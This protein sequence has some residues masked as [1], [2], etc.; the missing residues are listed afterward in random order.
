MCARENPFISYQNNS[1][2][3]HL[4]CRR[5]KQSVMNNTKIEQSPEAFRFK[6]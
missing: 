6:Q 2:W 5:K 3:M 4:Q 1:N